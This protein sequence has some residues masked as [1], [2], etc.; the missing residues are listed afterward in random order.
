MKG[1]KIFIFKAN[2]LTGENTLTASAG[3]CSHTVTVNGVTQANPDYALKEGEHSF[4]RNWF[5][6]SDEINSDCLSLNDDLGTLVNNGEVQKLMKTHLGKSIT[7]P[8]PLTKI[9][10]KPVYTLVS[11]N[12][13]GKELT[14]LANQFLQTVD[15][16]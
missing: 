3:E 14:D 11:K 4:V 15:K 7:I 1:D 10:L 12:K 6:A 2:I 8:S 13:K 9:P 16:D 5:E